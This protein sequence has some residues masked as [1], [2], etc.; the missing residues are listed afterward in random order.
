MQE[1]SYI[2]S[3][4]DGIVLVACYAEGAIEEIG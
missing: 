1:G 4:Y 2:K 3:I